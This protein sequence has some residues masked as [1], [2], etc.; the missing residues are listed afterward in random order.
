MTS[1]TTKRSLDLLRKHGYFVDV[2]EKWISFPER[3]NGHPTGKVMR[4]KR[5]CFSGFDLIAIRATKQG[6]LYVQT[7]TTQNQAARIAKVQALDVTVALLQAHNRVHVHGWKKLAKTGRWE[8]TVTALTLSG[9]DRLETQ[10]HP[11]AHVYGL[12]QL[13]EP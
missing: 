10:S 9:D 3:I 8:C 2:V 5:D 4:V 1:T 6:T 11:A 13:V 7:T 12:P